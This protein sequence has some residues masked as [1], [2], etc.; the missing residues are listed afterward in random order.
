M[1][2]S[3][4]RIP[5]KRTL[6]FHSPFTA[7]P[8]EW[9]KQTDCLPVVCSQEYKKLVCSKS[10][11]AVTPCG[12]VQFSIF[13]AIVWIPGCGILLPVHRNS[14]N[15]LFYFTR[16]SLLRYS[17]LTEKKII[18]RNITLLLQK[19]SFHTLHQPDVRKLFLSSEATISIS[20]FSR[21]SKVSW[22]SGTTVNPSRRIDRQRVSLIQW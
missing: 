7:L 13:P 19:E 15:T 5:C 20:A 8:P 1:L 12:C 10:R 16:I 3:I 21:V 14:A 2:P 4:R 6:Y 22:S 17:L 11:R 9:Q 18:V